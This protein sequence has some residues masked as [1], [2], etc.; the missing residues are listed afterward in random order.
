MKLENVDVAKL[1][2]NDLPKFD[3]CPCELCDDGC[4]DR[5]GYEHYP[6]CRQKPVQRTK[7]P[8][9]L[10]CPLSHYKATFK[11]PT[12]PAGGSAHQRRQP[13]PPAPDNEIPISFKNATMS[14]VSSQRDHYQPPPSSNIRKP[15]PKHNKPTGN[16]LLM[17]A[18]PME[19]KSSY[20]AEYVNRPIVPALLRPLKDVMKDSHMNIDEPTAP[21]SSITTARTDFQ[22]WNSARSDPYAE[23]PSVTEHV[24]FPG[25][26]RDFSTSTGS[27]FVPFPKV[28]QTRPAHRLEN[29]GN[30][31]LS[32]LMDLNTNYRDSY[33][34]HSTTSIRSAPSERKDEKVED[35]VYKRR[36]MFA[37]SQSSLDYRPY[38]NHQRSPP[39][40]MEPFVSQISLGSSL[41]PAVIKS[42]YRTDYEGIDASRHTRQPPAAPKDHNR[43]YVPPIQKMDTMS[44]TQRDFQPLDITTLPRIRLVPM[45]AT[46][47]MNDEQ[48]PMENVS[49]SRFH[50]KPY[51]SMKPKRQYSDPMPDIYVPPL[52]KFSGAT[53]TGDTYQGQPG[54]RAR[55]YIPEIR[56][57]NRTGEHDHR[58]NYRVDY[59]PHGLTL[60]AAKAFAIAQKKQK[61]ATPVT[62][63]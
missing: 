50:F 51:E 2:L 42:Q 22:P 14:G 38:P 29:R 49:M 17:R 61:P 55:A 9:N 12:Y 6:Q 45:K 18:V 47:S 58:T 24:L 62:A 63:Q 60:C 26:S 41:T 19:T 4:F 44:V 13:F 31:K 20:Q 8:I 28:S 1:Q 48:L 52:E 53:T 54:P 25:S 57:L 33:V 7:L 59:H 16:G 36:P 34:Q 39:A 43:P 3:K 5:A 23:F 32:G 46:F 56:M 35:K 30:L 27:T 21:L 10:R 37:I 40:D 11:S 15:L